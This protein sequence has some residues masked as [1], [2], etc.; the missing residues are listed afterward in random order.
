M[1]L[2]QLVY[3]IPTLTAWTKSSNTRQ[4]AQKEITR[5]KKAVFQK[6]VFQKQFFVHRLLNFR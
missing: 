4:A 1:F 3:V 2:A 6:L 5:F